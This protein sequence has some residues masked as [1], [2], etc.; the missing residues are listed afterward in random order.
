MALPKRGSMGKLYNNGPRCSDCGA[1]SLTGERCAHCTKRIALLEVGVKECSGCKQ[2]KPLDQFRHDPK[3]RFNR[4]SQCAECRDE[5]QR[6]Y[7]ATPKGKATKKRF[8]DKRKAEWPR[9]WPQ[10][11]NRSLRKHF[12]ISLAEYNIMKAQQKGLCAICNR[13]P[14]L[15]D[16]AVD[17]DHKTGKVRALL[18]GT[19]NRGIGQFN[20]DPIRLIKAVKYLLRFMEKEIGE[21]EVG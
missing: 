11:R 21:R 17:H 4:G 7:Y 8:D 12:G 10:E 16:L 2:T 18:C 3:M 15:K 9:L 19:C 13:L 14:M 20:D 6:R 1:F 5:A